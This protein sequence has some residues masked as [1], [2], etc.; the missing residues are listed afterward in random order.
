PGAYERTVTLSGFSKTFNMTGWRLG[1]AVA[2]PP[3]IEK[4]GLINDLVYICAPAPL[5]HGVAD[6]LPMPDAYYTEM[7]AAYDAK[8]LL[9]C[10]TLEACGFAFRRP[11]GAY[12][13]LANFE[14]LSR[15]RE[16]FADDRQATETLI[17]M[18]GVACV[19]GNSFFADPE[20]GRTWLRFCYAKEMDVLED[21]CRRLRAAFAPEATPA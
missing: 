5:Q 4:M 15:E 11:D 21:A 1:Y 7:Q 12:Y 16:G 19:P 9:M 20:D 3:V 6:A 2:A 13:V 10:D 8:R 17:E 18:A 14:R